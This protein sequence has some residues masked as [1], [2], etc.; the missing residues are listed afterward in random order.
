M[1]AKFLELLAKVRK[2][3]E[4]LKNTDNAKAFDTQHEKMKASGNSAAMMAEFKILR[5]KNLSMDVLGKL[6]DEFKSVQTLL[7]AALAH[8]RSF[9]ASAPPA[10][11]GRRHKKKK[12]R[13]SKK[14]SSTR[15]VRRSGY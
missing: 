5:E 13:R 12:T 2:E 1:E 15:R 7:Q 9:L 3:A 8:K 6:V 14:R 11:G 10:A 4:D